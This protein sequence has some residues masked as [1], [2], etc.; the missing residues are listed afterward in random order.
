MAGMMM[1][2][3][4]YYIQS[5]IGKE[6]E[7]EEEEEEEVIRIFASGAQHTLPS[8]A[9]VQNNPLRVSL[10]SFPPSF[11]LPSPLLPPPFSSLLPYCYHPGELVSCLG[12]CERILTTPI[13]LPYSRHTSR[14][15]SIFCLTLPFILVKQI[16]FLVIPVTIAI[17]WGLFSIEEIGHYIENPFYE[18]ANLIPM[19]R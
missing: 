17:C 12:M 14:M 7:E 15:L 6:E 11:P 16:G 4:Y 19:S 2:L 13:P 3:H 9:I 5:A 8:V 18:R 10:P 1:N